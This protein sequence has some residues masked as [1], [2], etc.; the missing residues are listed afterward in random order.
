MYFHSSCRIKDTNPAESRAITEQV[1]NMERLLAKL[2]LETQKKRDIL[3]WAQNQQSFL[4]DS[5]RLLLWAEG[6]QEK[7]SSEEMGVDVTSA[8][9]LLKEHQDLLKEIR[10]QKER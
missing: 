8:E 9:Q 3:Q 10:S 7:L 5:R 2:K 6:I 4:Q 1:E